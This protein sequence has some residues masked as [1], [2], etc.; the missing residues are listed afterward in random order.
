MAV[1]VVVMGMIVPMIVVVRMVM[2]VMMRMRMTVIVLRMDMVMRMA[3]F[4][5]LGRFAHG[6]FI[7]LRR[8]PAAANRAHHSTSSSF[9]RISSPAVI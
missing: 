2:V 6:L 5:A 7:F 4:F 1:V 9:T 8:R 3:V